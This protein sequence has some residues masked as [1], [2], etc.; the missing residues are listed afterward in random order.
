LVLSAH[1]FSELASSFYFAFGEKQHFANDATQLSESGMTRF[2]NGF[3]GAQDTILLVMVCRLSASYARF[4][5][6]GQKSPLTGR[7]TDGRPS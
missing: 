5:E 7:K 4:P 1:F 3:L 6:L 2:Q